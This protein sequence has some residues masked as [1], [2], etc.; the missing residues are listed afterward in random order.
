MFVFF[1]TK[2]FFYTRYEIQV[3]RLSGRESDDFV[4]LP[5]DSNFKEL[6]GPATICTI[7]QL[8]I[9]LCD[10]TGEGWVGWFLMSSESVNFKKGWFTQ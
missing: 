7:K 9:F 10:S 8:N 2:P 5:S 4:T 6:N 1:Y 3:L